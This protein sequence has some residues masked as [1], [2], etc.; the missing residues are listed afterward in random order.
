MVLKRILEAPTATVIV[1]TTTAIAIVQTNKKRPPK[2]V[3]TKGLPFEA[4]FLKRASILSEHQLG[5][6]SL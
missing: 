4:K 5:G 6:L 1:Q 3:L 2:N